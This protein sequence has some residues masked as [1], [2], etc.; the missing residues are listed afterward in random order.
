MDQGG[1]EKQQLEQL[2]LFIVQSSSLQEKQQL[3]Q[4]N[5]FIVQSSSLQSQEILPKVGWE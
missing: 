2:N 1:E 3:E 4:L 5:L